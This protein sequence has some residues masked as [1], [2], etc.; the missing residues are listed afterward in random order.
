[1][2]VCTRIKTTMDKVTSYKFTIMLNAKVIAIKTTG[3]KLCKQKLTP[4]PAEGYN[5][6]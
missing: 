3:T 5:T 4:I 2:D 1:M 6:Y